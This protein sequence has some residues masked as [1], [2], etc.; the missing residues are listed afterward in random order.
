MIGT[1]LAIFA[2]LPACT[3]EVSPAPVE[4]HEVAYSVTRLDAGPLPADLM[5]LKLSW[6]LEIRIDEDLPAYWAD[7]R[8]NPDLALGNDE[9]V[10]SWKYGYSSEAGV[11]QVTCLWMAPNLASTG[12]EMRSYLQPPPV[13]P[14]QIEGYELRQSIRFGFA[15]P[16]GRYIG[17]W[18]STRSDSERII[19]TFPG[20][21]SFGSATVLTRTSQPIAAVYVTPGH[22]AASL[23]VLTDPTVDGSF[24]V[25][26]YL[27]THQ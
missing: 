16:S 17:V 20:D 26:S 6:S 19:A 5:G 10:V 12:K 15:S 7:F 14:P 8:S 11:P 1:A 27:W 2:A 9:R 18:T 25:S 13:N 3:Q 24:T 21:A 4:A 22:G 23:I